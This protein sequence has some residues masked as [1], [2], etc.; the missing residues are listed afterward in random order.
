MAKYKCCDEFG[1]LERLHGW[2]DVN[3]DENEEKQLVIG[4]HISL[5]NKNGYQYIIFRHCPF[6]GNK[7]GDFGMKN[8]PHKLP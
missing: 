5:K 3:L 2:I 1:T 4:V 6:C 8:E 7:I